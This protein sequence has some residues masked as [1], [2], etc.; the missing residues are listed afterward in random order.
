[1]QVGSLVRLIDDPHKVLG[2]IDKVVDSWNLG[3]LYRVLW[4]DD[5]CDP[6]YCDEDGLEVV[7]K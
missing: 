6:C 3:V 7:C 5:S 2:V 1:M 4:L